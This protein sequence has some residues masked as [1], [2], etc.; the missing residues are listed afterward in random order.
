[1][2]H[3]PSPLS[4][5]ST[6]KLGNGTVPQIHPV[7][8]FVRITEFQS[9]GKMS[10]NLWEVRQLGLVTLEINHIKVLIHTLIIKC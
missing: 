10:T 6:F 1:M 2:A 9:T 7:L 3:G 5:H 8:W 4:L